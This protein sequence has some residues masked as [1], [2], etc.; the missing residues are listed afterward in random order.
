MDEDAVKEALRPA[1]RH[2]VS[3]PYLLSTRLTAC[4]AE[5]AEERDGKP[6][7]R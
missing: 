7:Q 3:C 4:H 6:E 5:K 2:L 1:K